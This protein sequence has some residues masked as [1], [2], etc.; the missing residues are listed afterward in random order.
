MSIEIV[1]GYSHPQIICGLFSEYT[2]LLSEG[3]PLFS[4]YLQLQNFEEEMAC[5]KTKYGHPEGRLYL[6][7]VNGEPAGCIALR[8]LDPQRC[9]MKR[10]Y[11]RPAFRGR[12]IGK[13]LTERVLVDA[14]SIGYHQI[15]LDTFPFLEQAIAMYRKLGFREIPQYNNSPVDSTIYMALA[16]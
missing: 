12:G 11:V 10:L 2:S 8:R 5:L 9:E 14:R 15:L 13:L 6:A 7:L 16:L 3:E 1:P 4:R